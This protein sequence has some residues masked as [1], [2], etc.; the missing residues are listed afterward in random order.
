DLMQLHCIP[1]RYLE[2]CEVFDWLRE[3][4]DEGK[5]R[6]FGASVETQEEAEICL[7]Q[8]DLASL[9]VIFNIFRQKPVDRLFKRAKRNGVALI[10]RLPLASGLLAGKYSRETTFAPSDHRTY[11]R[12]GEAFSVGETFSGLEFTLGLDCVEEVRRLVPA[13]MDMAHFALRWILDHTEVSVAIPGAAKV[14]QVK[15]NAAASD[16]PPLP[17]PVH[18]ALRRLYDEKIDRLIRGRR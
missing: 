13:G 8:S 11:N 14:A 9:Q 2:S 15:S 5:I 7:E 1:Q 17:K 16:L 3:L 18:T 12:N 4:R 6:A 10:V